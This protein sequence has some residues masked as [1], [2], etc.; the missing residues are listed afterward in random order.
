MSEEQIIEAASAVQ[1]SA[2]ASAY[3]AGIGY[4]VEKFQQELNDTVKYIKSQ[5]K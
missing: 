4:S 1:Q 5:T 2:G 3:L